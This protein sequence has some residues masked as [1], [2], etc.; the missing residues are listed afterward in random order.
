MLIALAP[1]AHGQGFLQRLKNRVVQKVEEKVEEAA[2]G[3]GAS[4]QGGSAPS[5][6]KA[7][8]NARTEAVPEVM[9]PRA[10]RGGAPRAG[11]S[12]AASE[13]SAA[14]SDAPTPVKYPNDLPRPAG[15]ESV[16]AASTAF[17]KVACSSCE[18]GYTYDS[19]VSFARDELSGKY[20]EIG[21]RLGAL[22]VGQV[23]RWKG[24]ESAGT[25]TVLAE[26]TVGGFRCR[27]LRY[28]LV[29]DRASAERPGLVCWGYGNRF[30]AS[31][32]WHEVY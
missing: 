2:G 15:F 7:A 1:P 19:W 8:A 3:L 30:S 9:T 21:K 22:D 29:K 5:R 13:T 6:N 31:E 10:V 17:G 11:A 14:P 32:D 12:A 26:E 16:N 27:R 20:N 23:H 4:S 25:L 28:K 18:G 24:V